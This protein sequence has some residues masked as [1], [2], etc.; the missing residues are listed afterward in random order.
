LHKNGELLATTGDVLRI[1]SLEEDDGEG[2]YG[3]GDTGGWRGGELG[4]RLGERNKL[5]NVKM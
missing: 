2:E 4:W 5:T 1:W 3:M